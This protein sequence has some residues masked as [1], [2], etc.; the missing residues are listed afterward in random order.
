MLNCAMIGAKRILQW[1]SVDAFE[2]TDRL[3]IH[4]SESVTTFSAWLS[5]RDHQ[6]DI[7]PKRGFITTP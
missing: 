2:F 6:P 4:F 3:G 5:L 1:A 7:I